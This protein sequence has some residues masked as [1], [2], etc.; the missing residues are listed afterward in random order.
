MGRGF[1]DDFL[2]F[3]SPA[4]CLSYY[5]IQ[6]RCILQIIYMHIWSHSSVLACTSFPP[7]KTGH[8]YSRFHYN[9]CYRTLNATIIP[10]FIAK[11]GTHPSETL[12]LT[13]Q[14]RGIVAWSNDQTTSTPFPASC[15]YSKILDIV[16]RIAFKTQRKNCMQ[17]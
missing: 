1:P 17:T 3:T 14:D 4:Y 11:S 7:L 2:P 10:I 9:V 6:P 16:F 15:N 12:G 13:T 8:C 5:S